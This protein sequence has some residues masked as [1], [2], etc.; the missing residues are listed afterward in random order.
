MKTAAVGGASQSVM[1]AQKA[2]RAT[3]S[4]IIMFI[5]SNKMKYN[6]VESPFKE[7]MAMSCK[8]KIDVR[9]YYS[10]NSDLD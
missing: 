10:P 5:A 1:D 8:Y 3:R 2:V 7:L 6:D 9:R 4:E